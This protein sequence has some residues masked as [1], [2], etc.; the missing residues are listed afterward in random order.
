MAEAVETQRKNWVFVIG[1]LILS[2]GMQFANYGTTVVVAGKV[3]FFLGGYMAA[4]VLYYRSFA[5]SLC[6][7]CKE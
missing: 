3:S 6:S 5:L 1:I 7:S 2:I 4:S